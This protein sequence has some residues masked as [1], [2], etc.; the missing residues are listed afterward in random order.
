MAKAAGGG[1]GGTTN[2]TCLIEIQHSY[3]YTV[4]VK[5]ITLS[6]DEATLAKVRKLAVERNSSINA[7]VREYLAQLASQAD[8]AQR[9]RKRLITLSRQ[10]S[11]RIG[12]K[13]W[14]RVELHER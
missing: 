13:T 10:S 4:E 6:V 9:A 11:A 8:R 3:T 1:R 12:D 14:T 7:L 5:N 2:R